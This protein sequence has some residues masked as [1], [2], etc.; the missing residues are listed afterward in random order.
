MSHTRNG[1]ERDDIFQD[2]C[3]HLPTSPNK[4]NP[5]ERILAPVNLSMEVK[6]RAPC[7]QIVVWKAGG[8]CSNTCLYAVIMSCN[9][10]VAECRPG[11]NFSVKA[12][13]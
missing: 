4:I 13:Q 9:K 8:K 7:Q 10:K 11:Q 1:M 3:H 5:P 2:E 6:I 12:K